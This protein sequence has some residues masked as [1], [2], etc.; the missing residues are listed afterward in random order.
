MEGVERQQSADPSAMITSSAERMVGM[1][2]A[3]VRYFTSYD[4]HGIHEEMLKDDVR[5]RSY[6]DSIYQNRHIFKDKVVLDVGCG[7]GI[8]S[9]FAAKA[10]AKHVIGVDMSSI[11]EKA[12]EI[13]AVNGL[14]DK[15]TLLQGKMEEVQ[16]PF[17]TVDIIISE[18]MGYF[19]LYESMLD[20]VLYARDRYLAPGGKI[21]PDKA[22]MYL[23]AIEDGEYKDDKI[24]FWDNVYGFDYSPMKEIA[25]TEPLVD[26]VELKALVSDPCSIITFDL[27]TVTKADLAFRVPFSLPV[28]RS[29]FIHA[30]I[31]WFD[32]DF[33]ACHKPIS[34]STGPHAKYTH[35]KQT[36]FYLRDVLTVEEEES[37][38]GILEN[39]PNDKNPRDLDIQISYK[40]ETADQLRYAEGN[41]FYRIHNLANQSCLYL[42]NPAIQAVGSRGLPNAVRPLTQNRQPVSI[43]RYSSIPPENETTSAQ[44]K[45]IPSNT[46][47]ETSATDEKKS[48]SAAPVNETS[49]T[50]A[51]GNTLADGDGTAFIEGKEILTATTNEASTADSE[52]A[53]RKTNAEFDSIPKNAA[54]R[55][56]SVRLGP[57][58]S[59]VTRYGEFHVNLTTERKTYSAPFKF[60]DF[61]S[62]NPNQDS[63]PEVEYSEVMS[64]DAAVLA[65]FDEIY[66]WGFCFVKGVPVDPESTKALLERISFIRHTHYGGFWDFTSD[67]TFKDTAYTTEFL[68]AHT[69]NTYFTDPARLQLFHLLSHTDGHGGASLLVDGFKAASIMRQ[70]NPKHCGVLAATKQPYHSS[71]NEDVCIQPAEQA[72]VFKI[73][74][75]LSRLYQVRWNNYDRAA[76]RDWG[77]KEQN[78]WYNAA[79]H[80][81]NIIQRPGVEIWTQLQ[82]GTALIFDNWRMLH[83]R[84]EFTGKRRMCG[85]YINNDDFISRYRLLKYGREKVIENLGNLAIFKG[86]PNFLL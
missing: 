2:H 69:D 71:G 39:K 42:T 23:A 84:S 29:D 52:T 61:S 83:G 77:L 19:L 44:E 26:T 56:V 34:F 32:I 67:L 70:E 54:R 38:S 48:P 45:Q 36:V 55:F 6:R 65:W 12:R 21:F 76:K 15:I 59:N 14:S 62:Y 53:D 41:C 74:P 82:P 78:R 28:K 80:F 16:L 60:R 33:T 3:E 4:H 17:P 63:Y 86:N 51:N 50:E 8:L 1:D 57:L 66:K 40:L 31:A 72:P 30:I 9:M 11:I 20:T 27:Y 85:G 10:G 18:W 68:G 58:G 25:L 35:W 13:V 64:D 5:T 37:V 7:T 47:S 24:G 46:S 81:N 79:R 22:T 73:H 49:S 75:E 43:R